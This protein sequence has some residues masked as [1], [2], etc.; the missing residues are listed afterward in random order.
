MK[1]KSGYMLREVAGHNVVFPLGSR[2]A[3]FT[4]L[5]TLNETGAFL[6]NNMKEEITE[7]DLVNRLVGEYKVEIAT[8]EQDVSEFIVILRE[9]KLLEQE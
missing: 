9:N 7:K 8:A 4:G 1:I 2:T 6:W 3:E 5:I